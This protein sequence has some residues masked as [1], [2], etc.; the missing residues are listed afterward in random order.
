M[1]SVRDSSN[2]PVGKNPLHENQKS[3]YL[4]LMMEK[5]GAGSNTVFGERSVKRIFWPRGSAQPPEKAQF[6]QGNP[7]KS[8]PFSLIH[9]AWSQPGFAGFCRIWV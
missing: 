9:F 3:W 4:D 5:R 8:K 7:R 1:V 2:Y 6:G